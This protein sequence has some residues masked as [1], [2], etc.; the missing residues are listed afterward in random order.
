MPVGI[1][2]SIGSLN[3]TK[4]LKKGEFLS[5]KLEHGSSP[6][7]DMDVPDCWTAGIRPGLISTPLVLRLPDSD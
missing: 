4:K 3:R 6:T 7:L 1:N 5:A 2:Q